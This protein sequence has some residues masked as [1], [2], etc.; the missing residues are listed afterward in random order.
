MSPVAEDLARLV[1]QGRE[2]LKPSLRECRDLLGFGHGCAW[3][4]V[5]N[6]PTR[7]GMDSLMFAP[8]CIQRDPTT[9]NLEAGR[10]DNADLIY[11]TDGRTRWFDAVSKI[12]RGYHLRSWKLLSKMKEDFSWNDDLRV[13]SQ[14][15]EF[16]E[17]H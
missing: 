11:H 16:T 10:G 17:R 4:L 14:D 7:S 6:T 8:I 15:P 1:R 3:D 12:R 2:D 5:A 13:L 9:E